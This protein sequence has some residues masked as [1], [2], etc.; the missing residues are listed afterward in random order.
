MPCRL[1]GN[2]FGMSIKTT[3]T[4]RNILLFD[5]VVPSR[6][7]GP[8]DIISQSV[9]DLTETDST[10]VST[11][12]SGRTTMTM[13]ND[14][15]AA[16][17]A[18]DSTT[19]PPPLSSSVLSLLSCSQEQELKSEERAQKEFRERLAT[20]SPATFFAKPPSLSPIVCARFG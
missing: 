9:P 14:I 7:P 18:A 6:P 16:V 20:F 10:T 1:S 8:G 19:S 4:T 3:A 5:S 2:S 17:V 13:I 15:S 12:S 11:H